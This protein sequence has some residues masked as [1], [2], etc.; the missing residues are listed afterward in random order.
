MGGGGGGVASFRAVHA[1]AWTGGDFVQGLSTAP[2]KKVFLRKENATMT[3]GEWIAL[4]GFVTI[5]A[6]ALA[7]VIKQLESSKCTEIDACCLKC[8]RRV[9]DTADDEPKLVRP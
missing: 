6:S 8:K 9:P 2:D 4:G 3:E 5:C 7:L 1:R